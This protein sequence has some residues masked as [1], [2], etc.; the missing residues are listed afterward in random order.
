M[1]KGFFLIDCSNFP[2][3]FRSIG[4]GGGGGGGGDST[5]GREAAANI[6]IKM[7]TIIA[8]IFFHEST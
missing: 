4:G 6:W 7:K 1:K 3:V 8:L 2:M 5:K